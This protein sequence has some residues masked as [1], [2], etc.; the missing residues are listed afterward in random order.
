VAL[1]STI[2]L[3][4]IAVFYLTVR[5]TTW[6]QEYLSN[7]RGF[8]TSN[9]IDSFASDN[10]ARFTL[11]NLQVPFFSL[12]HRTDSANF[13]AFVVTGVL[14]SAW[15]FL[16]LKTKEKHEFVALGAI[17]TISLLPIYHRFYDAAILAIPLCWCLAELTRSLKPLALCGLFL[18][19]PFFFPGTALLGRLASHNRL[20]SSLTRSWIWDFLI[21]P[22]ETWALLLLSAILLYAIHAT[23]KRD[24]GS[25][26]RNRTRPNLGFALPRDNKPPR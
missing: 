12:T 6:L 18:L 13:G 10:P 7:A 14:V 8:V 24:L 23:A 22:H 19:T 11:L 25:R 3:N 26:L 15:I 2:A 1:G 20:P 4:L 16:I 21:M 5:G 9:S 17:S